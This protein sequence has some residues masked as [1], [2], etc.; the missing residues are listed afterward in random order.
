MTFGATSAARSA[1]GLNLIGIAGA[2][3]RI[4]WKP[5]L[6]IALFRPHMSQEAAMSPSPDAIA[7]LQAD[8]QKTEMMLGRLRDN[9]DGPEKERLIN[10]LGRVLAFRAQTLTKIAFPAFRAACV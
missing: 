4:G 6:S 2:R 10:E 3:A 9:I 7:I 5:R 8:D 1:A